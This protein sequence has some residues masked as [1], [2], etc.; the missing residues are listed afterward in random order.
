MFIS[1]CTNK[2]GKIDSKYWQYIFQCSYILVN[3]SLGRNAELF[4]GPARAPE[5]DTTRRE[6]DLARSVQTVTEEIVGA[7]LYLASDASSYTTG[8]VI[9]ID[10]GM[11]W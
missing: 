2:L 5:S 7:A 1:R 9:T 11:T 3:K 8:S 4:G 6:M 10:G